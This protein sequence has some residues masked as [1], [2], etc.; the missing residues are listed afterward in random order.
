MLMDYSRQVRRFLHDPKMIHL[1]EP[2]IH[3]YINRARREVALRSQSIRRVPPISGSIYRIDVLLPGAGYTNPNVVIAPPDSPDGM[4]PTPAGGEAMALANQI[5]GLISNVSVSYGGAGYF[6]PTAVITDPTGDGA[7]LNCIT[8][9]LSL[10]QPF[11]ETYAFAD[12]P[13][14]QFPG[15]KSVFAVLDVSV[16]YS[17]YRYSLS[18]YAFSV[19]Q[20]MIRQFPRQYYYVPTMYTQFQQGAQGSLLMYPLPSQQ[21]QIEFDCLCLPTDMVY[22]DDFEP[23][24][25]PFTDAVPYL[26]ACLCYQ[27]LQNANMARYYQEQYDNYVHRYAAYS[28]PGRTNNPYGRY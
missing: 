26:A 5:G 2:D 13:V 19:Y 24:P 6:Q 8:V 1:D 27:E 25:E 7:V 28:R 10:L 14:S 17:N 9:P 20:A 23:I 21:F 12:M 15:V 18:Y 3:S 16:I 22:G 11:Q 4:R